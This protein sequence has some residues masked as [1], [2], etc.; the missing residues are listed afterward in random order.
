M[1]RA[2]TVDD[3]PSSG[4]CQVAC[5]ACGRRVIVVDRYVTDWPPIP[6]FNPEAF[7]EFYSDWGGDPDDRVSECPGCGDC[8]DLD[9]VLQLHSY[10]Y[11]QRWFGWRSENEPIL[12]VILCIPLRLLEHNSAG[13]AFLPEWERYFARSQ[14]RPAIST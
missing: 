2:M 13:C 1:P 8:L 11:G 3:I 9:T 4:S 7:V 12:A 5:G 6:R 14:W 10:N